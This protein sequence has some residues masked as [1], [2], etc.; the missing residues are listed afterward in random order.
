MK[1]INAAKR[2]PQD[3]RKVKVRHTT[4]TKRDLTNSDF[5]L[6][7]EGLGVWTAALETDVFHPF[8]EFEWL[9][10]AAPSSIYDIDEELLAD[11][12]NKLT[13]AYNL[14]QM[15]LAEDLKDSCALPLIK[16]EALK[17]IKEIDKLTQKRKK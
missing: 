1:W 16:R 10:E 3:W 2:K 4:P 7:K 9:D 12:R 11:L 17:V 8:N 13:P 14:A 6:L 15:V 5:C